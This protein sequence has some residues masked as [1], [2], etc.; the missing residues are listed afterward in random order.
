MMTA[1]QDLSARTHR[2]PVGA[3]PIRIAFFWVAVKRRFN[4][5]HYG[6]GRVRHRASGVS[7]EH[8][9]ERQALSQE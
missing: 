3:S 9:P 1:L 8:V 5:S 2:D 6:I 4:G 7:P